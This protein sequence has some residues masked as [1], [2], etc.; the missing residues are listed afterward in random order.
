VDCVEV[1]EETVVVIGSGPTDPEMCGQK[2]DSHTVVRMWNHEWQPVERY[3]ARFDFGLITTMQDAHDAPMRPAKS[4]LFYNVPSN[5]LVP[6]VNG[7]SVI[8]WNHRRYF[9]RAIAQG[10]R[11]VSGRTVK[12]TRGFAAVAA[13]IEYLRPQRV[14]V[15]GMDILRNGVTG[16]RYYDPAA[17]PWY[18]KQYP[19]MTRIPGW[20]ANEMPEGVSREGPHDYGTEA[21]LIR[22]LAAEYGVEL[23]W[24]LP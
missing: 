3:G 16:A 7:K 18:V 24:T 1:N 11:S 14:V 4:W 6:E 9:D 13:T 8:L 2:V 22:A 10:A 17:L 19:G 20:E 12:F 21:S 5:P 15:I 23:V